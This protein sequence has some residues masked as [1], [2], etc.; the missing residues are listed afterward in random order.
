M[1]KHRY[2]W[3]LV[4]VLLVAACGKQQPETKS[5]ADRDKPAY[6]LA[7]ID[8]GDTGRNDPKI[9]PYAKLLDSVM[10]KCRSGDRQ[11]LADTVSA[12]TEVAEN[13]GRTISQLEMLRAMEESVPAGAEMSQSCRD[14]AT[15]V[16]VIMT[17]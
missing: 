15:A 8:D 6:L 1:K 14:V 3:W 2:V 13:E 16:V 11:A 5:W 10:T 12:A 4:V 9:E 7:V 17:S